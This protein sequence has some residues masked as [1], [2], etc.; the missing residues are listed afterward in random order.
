MKRHRSVR[1][2]RGQ[3]LMA[4]LGEAPN[5]TP[6]GFASRLAARFGSYFE[7]KT[8]ADANGIPFATETDFDP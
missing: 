4:L 6:H 1:S 5:H 2:V 3:R 7:I 8:Y